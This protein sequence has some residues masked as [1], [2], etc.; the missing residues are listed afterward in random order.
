MRKSLP[1]WCLFCG[2]LTMQSCFAETSMILRSDPMDEQLPSLNDLDAIS[3]TPA[4][5][6]ALTLNQAVNRAVFWHP[7]ISEAIGKLSQQTEAVNAAK[8]KYYPQISG[9][10]EN[11][12]SSAYSDSSFSPSLVLSLSQMLYDF[13]KTASQVRAE[14]AGVVQQQA[15]VLVSIDTVAQETA[16]ALIEVQTWQEMVNIAHDQLDALLAIGTLARRRNDEGASSLSDVVQTEARIE[17]ARSQLLQYQANLN[18]SRATLMTY[19]GWKNLNDVSR[20]YPETFNQSCNLAEPDDRLIPAVLAAWAQTNVAQANLDNAEAQMTPTISLEPEV[21]HY[22][23]DRYANHAIMDKTQYSAWVKVQMPLY[24]GGGLN[25][26]RAAAGYALKTA[27]SALQRTR[28]EV[29]QKL[30]ESRSQASSLANTVQVN[31]RQE[32]LSERTRELYQQ[33]YLDLGSHPLLDVLNAEQEV[34]QSRFTQQET[35]GQLH[36]LHISCLYN[37][38]QLRNRFGLENKPIQSLEIQP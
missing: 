21:R 19:L 7:S 20:E 6:G 4:A 35:L 28:L 14:N 16:S 3:D 37:T 5:P 36:Q 26:Q 17:G 25:A 9:G 2:L 30:M 29:R 13:G 15:N 10:I 33:Q 38:G 34:F 24:Q 22:L 27:H 8:S 18:S 11:E 12:Y 1:Y 32:I 23:N 31:A